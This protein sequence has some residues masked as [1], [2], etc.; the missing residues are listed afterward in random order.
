MTK[1]ILEFE[2]YDEQNKTTI[3]VDIKTGEKHYV[4]DRNK[5]VSCPFCEERMVVGKKLDDEYDSD[6]ERE[7]ARTRLES[8]LMDVEKENGGYVDMIKDNCPK[9]WKER[10]QKHW[11][12]DVGANYEQ[13]THTHECPNC[14]TTYPENPEEVYKGT[15][16]PR[17]LT[18]KVDKFKQKM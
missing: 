15:Y 12:S 5:I 3:L 11:L 1:P 2:K 8:P 6:D 4:P 14:E 7:R 16:F 10:R 17:D 13:T 18:V 9:C